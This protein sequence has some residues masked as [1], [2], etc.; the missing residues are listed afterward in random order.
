MI[1]SARVVGAGEHGLY[2]EIVGASIRDR[3]RRELHVARSDVNDDRSTIPQDK[4]GTAKTA[5][6]SK[7]DLVLLMTIIRIEKGGQSCPPS[8]I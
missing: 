7:E 5:C 4:E 2:R 8:S 6:M 3:L 1:I